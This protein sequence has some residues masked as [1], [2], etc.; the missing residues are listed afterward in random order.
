MRT[1]EP[2]ISEIGH[3]CAECAEEIPSQKG[4][5]VVYWSIPYFFCRPSC[6]KRWL[7]KRRQQDVE[8]QYKFALSSA[9]EIQLALGHL[10]KEQESA[11]FCRN[12]FRQVGHLAELALQG[13]S[14][15]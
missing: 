3:F 12:V 13:L 14:D 8:R 5:L 15:E 2:Q 11:E 1:M 6:A 7:E 4:R 9:H 10:E